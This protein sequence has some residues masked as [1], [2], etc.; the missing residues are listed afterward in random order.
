MHRRISFPFQWSCSSQDLRWQLSSSI[1]AAGQGSGIQHI[2]GYSLNPVL[3]S[4]LQPRAGNLLVSPLVIRFYPSQAVPRLSRA[5]GQE[6]KLKGPRN[7]PGHRHLCRVETPPLVQGDLQ[8]IQSPPIAGAVRALA[9][10]ADRKGKKPKSKQKPL[11]ETINLKL[12]A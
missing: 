9:P 6:P 3:S 7:A 8:S 11:P 12:I 1:P 5:A 2:K 4:L 10:Q